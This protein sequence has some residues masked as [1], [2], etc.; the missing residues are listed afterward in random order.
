MVDGG[1]VG[2]TSQAARRRAEG[3]REEHLR[4]A[5]L[6]L[7]ACFLFL[8]EPGCFLAL[9]LP[10]ARV[11]QSCLLSFDAAFLRNAQRRRREAGFV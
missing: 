2:Q 10:L 11:Q 9:P 4:L 1:E 7:A 8:S 6:L 5:A 3:A